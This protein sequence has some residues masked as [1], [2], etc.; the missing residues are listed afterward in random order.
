[1]PDRQTQRVADRQAVLG[2][3]GA[4]VLTVALVGSLWYLLPPVPETDAVIEIAP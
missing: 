3:L 4:A 2:L 1:M